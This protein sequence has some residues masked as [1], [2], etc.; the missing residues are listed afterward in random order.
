MEPII[1]NSTGIILI[2]L[3]IWW[4]LI[5][6]PKAKV[7]AHETLEVIVKDGVYD[8]S[9]IKIQCNKPLKICFLRKDNSPC[10]EYVIFDKLNISAR[11]P[12]GKSYTISIPTSKP[13]EYEF[14]CQ[15]G[16]YRGKLIIE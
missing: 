2:A 15:M 7:V 4:F 6:K 10:S 3:V 11:L 5:S 1:I 8:P 12:Y 16:M 13:G 9:F 14:T